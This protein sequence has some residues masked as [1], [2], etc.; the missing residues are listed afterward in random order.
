MSQREQ[1]G[2]RSK[3]RQI[4]R[5]GESVDTRSGVPGITRRIR[6]DVRPERELTWAGGSFGG[7]G[8]RLGWEGGWGPEPMDKLDATTATM[9]AVMKG[10]EDGPA[11]NWHGIDWRR[12]E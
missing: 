2:P 8:G 6:T 1:D 12:E 7:S 11:L 5:S 9:V 10:P 4:E 3:R